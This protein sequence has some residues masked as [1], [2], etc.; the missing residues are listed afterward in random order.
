MLLPS[1][2]HSASIWHSAILSDRLRFSLEAIIL[3]TVIKFIV[4]P[5]EKNPIGISFGSD[6]YRIFFYAY[7]FLRLTCQK[8]SLPVIS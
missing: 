4:Y 3:Q 1:E 2:M 7:R 6:A 8:S 5:T